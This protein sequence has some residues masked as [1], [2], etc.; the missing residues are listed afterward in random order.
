[1]A[2]A[3]VSFV[4]ERL[5]N[6]LIEEGQL[7]LG[8]RGQVESIKREL[9]RIQCLL[10]DADAKQKEGDER[11]R[12]WVA[13]IRDLSYDADDIIDTFTLS[14]AAKIA[15][16]RRGALVGCMSLQQIS[17]LKTR[18]KVGKEIRQ[19]KLMIAE[20]SNGLVTYGI[21][22]INDQAGEQDAR[23]GERRRLNAMFEEQDVVG[24]QEEMAIL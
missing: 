23:L 2:E 17:E 22:D 7:L 18:Y 20:I 11:V 16:W 24:F 8:V 15:R 1:M 4:V 10:K 19:I 12:N 6:L 3:I 13:E 9:K 21:K 14:Q 5:G